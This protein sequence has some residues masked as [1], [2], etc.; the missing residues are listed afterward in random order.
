MPFNRWE[1]VTRL[2]C[3][4]ITGSGKQDGAAK[5]H[6]EVCVRVFRSVPYYPLVNTHKELLKMAIEIVDL[7]TKHGNFP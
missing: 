1:E 5:N 4:K 6:C 3:P 2:D 7:P